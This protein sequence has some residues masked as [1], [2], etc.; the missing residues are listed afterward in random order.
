MSETASIVLAIASASEVGRIDGGRTVVLRLMTPDD[1]EVVLVMPQ[2][3]AHDI[4]NQIALSP[5]SETASPR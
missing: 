5:R 2:A 1:R 4:A 3:L